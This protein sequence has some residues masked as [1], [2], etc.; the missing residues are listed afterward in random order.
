MIFFETLGLLLMS[1]IILKFARLSSKLAALYNIL[2]RPIVLTFVLLIVLSFIFT[3]LSF[4]AMQ[5]WG[6]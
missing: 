1:L 2:E 6:V 4:T 3:L 5:L